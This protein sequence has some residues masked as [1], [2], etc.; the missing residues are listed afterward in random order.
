MSS[1][2]P[3]HP[4]LEW[5]RKTA[6][7]RLSALRVADP[8]ATLADAQRD[9]ARE[10]GFLSWRK[11][12]AH[13]ES[14][15]VVVEPPPQPAAD[16]IVKGFFGLV[17]AGRLDD[18]RKVLAAA[19]Q[20]VN[21]VGP[22]PFW[23]G[24]PQALHVAIE[25]GRR[26]L[27][28]LLLEHGADVNGRN[29]EYDHWSPLMLTMNRDRGEMRDELL[30]RG[31]RIG[32]IEALMMADGARVD[33]LLDASGLPAITPNGGSILAFARTT[34]AI[35]R[36]I[37]LGAS[38]D[39]K[40]RWG[41]TPLDA[42]SRLGARGIPLVNHMIA[43]GVAASPKEYARLGDIETLAAMAANDPS[44]AKQDS[45]MMAAVDFRH[46]ALA[47][48]LL[49]HGANVN[50]RADAQS[51]QTPLHNAAWNGDLRMVQLLIAAGADASLL[52][53]EHQGTPLQWAE[54]S[55]RVTNNPKCGEVAEYLRTVDSR[56]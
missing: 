18:V 8:Q 39:A 23:G 5:L 54:V 51:H 21:A 37:A 2:L 16:Q 20:F 26:D 41:A 40:D 30:R 35:D 56:L 22:H 48:W 11:L 34:H 28:D 27:F 1:S 43:R 10:Y 44:I 6:K 33:E 53:E 52:D 36:L 17:G 14:A 46:Y 9:V 42:M 3:S 32:L 50:A 24:R 31:A 55:A 19:P 13:V 29:D 7:Q 49:A 47:E 25:G 45:V 12:K 38:P 15:A 4:N